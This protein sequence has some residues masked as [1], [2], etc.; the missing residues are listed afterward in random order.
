MAVAVTFKMIYRPG[1]LKDGELTPGTWGDYVDTK[2][3]TKVTAY[4]HLFTTTW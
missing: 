1:A 4:Q 2:D 3:T